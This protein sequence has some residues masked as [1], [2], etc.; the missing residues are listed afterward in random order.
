ML[1]PGDL[2]SLLYAFNR[3]LLWLRKQSEYPMETAD[4]YLQTIPASILAAVVRGEVDLNELAWRELT[5]RG[6]NSEGKWVGF[7]EAERLQAL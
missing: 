2:I 6:M 1:L 5:S 4:M 7:Q 3:A